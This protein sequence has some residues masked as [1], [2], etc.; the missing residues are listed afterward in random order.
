M[1]LE[2]LSEQW[3]PQSNL[4]NPVNLSEEAG[5]RLKFSL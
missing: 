2:V 4:E 3:S 5:G 1:V